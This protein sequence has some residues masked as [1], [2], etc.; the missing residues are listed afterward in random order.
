MSSRIQKKE[1]VSRI[2]KRIA[3]DEK[4]AE[5][6]L[7]ATLETLYDAFKAGESVT[8]PGFGSFYV[9]EER[10]SWVFKF[11]PSQKLRAL[12]GWSSTYTGDL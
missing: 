5:A 2:A 7:D 11:N 6:Y 1:V 12:F 10:A 9:R 8:L 4:F 3:T